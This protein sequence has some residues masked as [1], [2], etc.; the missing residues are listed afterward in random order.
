MGNLIEGRVGGHQMHKCMYV[1]R[2]HPLQPLKQPLH[3]VTLL[4]ER[5]DYINVQGA[6]VTHTKLATLYSLG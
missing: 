2:S 4:Q 5:N 6:T 3:E 1:L